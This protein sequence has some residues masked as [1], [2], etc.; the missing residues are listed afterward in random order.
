M[1]I[2]PCAFAVS[3]T[4]EMTRTSELRLVQKPL[5]VES[6]DFTVTFYAPSRLV[7]LARMPLEMLEDVRETSI[8]K[9][10]ND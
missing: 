2:S 5:L 4:F 7:S 1:L 3:G 8:F 6:Y 9:V 10:E